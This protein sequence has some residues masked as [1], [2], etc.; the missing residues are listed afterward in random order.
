M[1]TGL[2]SS[3]GWTVAYEDSQAIVLNA[4]SRAI[5]TAPARQ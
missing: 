4:P 5:Q 3:S 2:R 1:A